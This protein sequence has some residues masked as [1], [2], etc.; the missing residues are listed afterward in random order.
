VRI[1]A[2]KCAVEEGIFPAPRLI[3]SG[4]ALSQTGGHCDF[5]GRFNDNPAPNTGF[6]LGSLGGSA[7]GCRRFGARPAR[8]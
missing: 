3:I 8:K 4:K 2:L 6:R 1:L 5:R 7:T